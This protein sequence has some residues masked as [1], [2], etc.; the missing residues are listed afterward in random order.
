[1]GAE[2]ESEEIEEI[3]VYPGWK[4]YLQEKGPSRVVVEAEQKREIQP[5]DDA[6]WQ[7]IMGDP[8]SPDLYESSPS[9]SAI[10]G[11]SSREGADS[12]D[13]QLDASESLEDEL[14][15]QAGE[16]RESS[17]NP[18]E[19]AALDDSAETYR[20]LMEL[21]TQPVL[22]TPVRDLHDTEG[23]VS[24]RIPQT[25]NQSS[26]IRQGSRARFEIRRQ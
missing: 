19:A 1:M 5:L 12:S 26:V 24:F 4:G 23:R 15:A 14:Q 6:I 21:F 7:L 25:D 20:R 16:R 10:A 11:N 9:E 22:T 17:S 2:L 18:Q 8:A 13:Q 3:P